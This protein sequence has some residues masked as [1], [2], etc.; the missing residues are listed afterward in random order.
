MENKKKT[1]K[2]P[3]SSPIHEEIMV[4]KKPSLEDKS[5]IEI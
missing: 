4:T 5:M 1:S 3:K 2:T